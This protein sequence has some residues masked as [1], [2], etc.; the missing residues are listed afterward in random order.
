MGD[1]AKKWTQTQNWLNPVHVSLNKK[2]DTLNRLFP[3]PPS[4]HVMKDMSPTT[5]ICC[6]GNVCCSQIPFH[7][8]VHA[9]F[10]MVSLLILFF[11]ITV[12]VVLEPKMKNADDTPL[13]GSW[14]T[15]SGRDSSDRHSELILGDGGSNMGL[16]CNGPIVVGPATLITPKDGMSMM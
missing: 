9:L 3:S 13:L 2:L 12:K 16:D 1:I 5:H 6:K 8:S 11:V 4:S 14:G 15:R 10:L 7:A